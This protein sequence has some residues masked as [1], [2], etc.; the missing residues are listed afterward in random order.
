MDNRIDNFFSIQNTV[1]HI[2]DNDYKQV[3]DYLEPIRAFARTSYKSIY[4]ID[5]QKKCL[6]YVS[7]NPLLLCGHT[8]KE[9]KE[10]GYGFYF[11]FVPKEDLDLLLKINT[12]WFNFYDNI[13]LEERKR[14][15]ILYDFRLKNKNGK[16][17]LVNHKLTPLFL[18][19]NG[20]IW[21]AICIVSLSSRHHSGN[22]KIYKQGSNKFWRYDLEN[23]FW[24]VEEKVVLT[25]REKEILRYSA[26][27]YTINEIAEIIF[28]SPATI[29]FHRQ[30][31][32]E[33]LHV[34][35]ITEA[36]SFA[37]N[38]KLI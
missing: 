25:E 14:Y 19:S 3:H 38:N 20:K 17:I 23:N 4:V 35:N 27:G 10:M 30:K 1:N 24:K 9:V 6:D 31:L 34:S 13:S 29:K 11:N 7:D 21:K 15:T 33:D 5:Y 12:V 37:I 22:V 32:F 18:T 26:Q 2:S 16:T 36:I 8:A 28:L